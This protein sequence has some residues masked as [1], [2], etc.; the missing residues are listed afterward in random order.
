[1]SVLITAPT[2]SIDK[3][4][5]KKGD[6]IR[7]QYHAWSSA[8]NGLVA[9]VSLSEIRVLYIVKSNSMTSYFTISADEIAAGLWDLSWSSNFTDIR[10][11]DDGL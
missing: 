11:E 8:Y 4:Q 1:M 9:A 6:F 5:I 7:A 10:T 2:T 3:T